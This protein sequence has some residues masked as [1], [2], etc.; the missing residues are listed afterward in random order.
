MR[1]LRFQQLY[2]PRPKDLK[3]ATLNNKLRNINYSS[4]KSSNSVSAK[5]TFTTIPACASELLPCSPVPKAGFAG[6]LQRQL[7]HKCSV[8]HVCARLARHR[9]CFHMLPPLLLWMLRLLPYKSHGKQKYSGEARDF[10][11][12]ILSAVCPLRHITRYQQPWQQPSNTSELHHHHISGCALLSLGTST[13]SYIDTASQDPLQGRW[14]G[15]TGIRHPATAPSS[16]LTLQIW[17]SKTL[18]CPFLRWNQS[19]QRL[20][21][22]TMR[23]LAVLLFCW[24]GRGWGWYLALFVCMLRSSLSRHRPINTCILGV[25]EVHI[26]ILL[27][28]L[29]QIFS[30]FTLLSAAFH[31]RQT[32]CVPQTK[33]RKRCNALIHNAICLKAFS[34]DHSPAKEFQWA[35]TTAPSDGSCFLCAGN[36]SLCCRLHGLE[37][38]WHHLTPRLQTGEFIPP[39]AWQGWYSEELHLIQ[40][41]V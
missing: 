27:P 1:C 10:R 3:I 14:E 26:R 30:P 6:S 38:N 21:E 20:T 19:H 17:G 39:S 5:H 34:L 25:V 11:A 2:I 15:G 35:T 41:R 37:T 22:V 12:I 7:S 8:P 23:G 31:S 24:G 29:V 18:I 28:C 36:K 13:G 16:T 40:C 32:T 4:H 9:S 33:K